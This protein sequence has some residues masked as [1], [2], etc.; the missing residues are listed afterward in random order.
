[1]QQYNNEDESEKEQLEKERLEEERL[2]REM[3]EMQRMDRQKDE[4]KLFP[5]NMLFVIPSWSALLG[6]PPLGKYANHDVLNIETDL[7]LFL[8]GYDYSIETKNGYLHFLF[9][10]GFY[11]LKFELESGKY[12]TDH[13]ILTGLVLTDFVYDHMATSKSIT[14]EEDRDIVIAEK[15][16]RVPVNLSDKPE[17]HLTFIKGAL[18]RNFFIPYKDIFLE[19]ISHIQDPLAYDIHRHGH[20]LLSTHWNYYNKILVAEKMRVN[21]YKS[22]MNSMAG[23]NGIVYNAD[24]L[25]NETMSSINLQII[26][27]NITYLKGVYS[28]VAFDPMYIFSILENASTMFSLEGSKIPTDPGTTP[29]QALFASTADRMDAFISW[30]IQYP[31]RAREEPQPLPPIIQQYADYLQKGTYQGADNEKIKQ[32]HYERDY[33][34][35]NA[36]KAGKVQFKSLPAPPE[37][38]IKK[39]LNYLKEIIQGEYEM[40]LI[41]T[42][43]EIARDK[44]RQI[45]ISSIS[46]LQKNIWEMSKYANIYSKKESNLGLPIKDK[47]EL[48]ERVH[49]WIFEIEDVERKERERLEHIKLEKER[50]ERRKLEQVRLE[51][52]RQ[53]RQKLEQVRYEKERREREILERER[54]EMVRLEKE[55]MEKIERK[56][57]EEL[58]LKEERK[59]KEREVELAL[60]KEKRELEKLKRERKLKEKLAKQKAKK[61][62]QLHKQ[63][64]KVEK[65]KQKEQQKLQNL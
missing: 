18:M 47:N 52:E 19:F 42:A 15:V 51:K 14:L 65:K 34:E 24:N 9:G 11:F 26:E 61:E 10:L 48:L 5:N 16:I 45:S 1:M 25:L 32:P 50:Q 30:P 29:K 59:N 22:Y 39:I 58:R 33:F 17:N 7:V 64:E 8:C 6:Y 63:R 31:R 46:G 36:L 13:R 54:L 3:L 20:M 55:R 57:Q 12:I 41:G 38:D 23:L 2:E 40:R 56:K 49:K 27:Q 44:M 28:S 4:N 37:V 43:F 21:P 62:K 53:E 35:I 60:Q